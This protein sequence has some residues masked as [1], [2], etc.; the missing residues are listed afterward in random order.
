MSVRAVT[1]DIDTLCVNALRVLA[2][3]AVERAGSG[4]PGAPMGLAPVAYTLWG[5]ALRHDPTDPGWPDRDRFVLSAGHASALLYALL[6]LF[7]YELPLEELRRFRQWGSRTPG[8]PEHGLT[9]GVETTT[10]PLGQGLAN[11]VGM[12]IAERILAARF[13]R[14]GLEIV[15]HRVFAIC[16]DGDLMEGIAH[17]AASLAG[18]LG[19]GKLIVCYDD[20][21]ITIDGPTDLASSEDVAGRFRAYGWGV[22]RVE[23]GRDLRA[24]ARALDGAMAERDRPSL[25]LVRTTIAE[26]APT[27]AGTAE[28]HGAPL[29]SEEVAAWKGE[30]GWPDEPFHVPGAVRARFAEL[31][32]EGMRH[33]RAWVDRFARWRRAEPE[34]AS[35]WDRVM[36]RR[37]PA[38]WVE[39]LPELGERMAT[40]KAS[41]AV[42]AAL[43]PILPEL[44]GGSADLSGSNNTFLPGN[45]A[46]RRDRPGRYL[47]FGVREHAMGGVL[48]GIALHG[49]MRPYGGTFLVFSD[50]LR[51]AIR[52]SALMR[53]PVVY[54]FTHDSI[55]LG[56]DG[57]T[58]QPIEQLASLR[59]IPGLVV[60][61]PADGAE[62]VW[63]WRVALERIDGPTAIVLTRQDVPA[64]GP[65]RRTPASGL[66]R[67]AYVLAELA[68]EAA[69][70]P[71]APDPE[72]RPDA[73][74]IGTGSEV[75]LALEAARI[76]AAEGA[77]V[78]VVSMPSWELFERQPS[79]Y[80]DL[81][82]PPSVRARVAVEAGVTQGWERWVGDRGAVVGIDRFGASAPGP[83]LMERFGFTAERVASVVRGVLA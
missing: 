73:V 67:G 39:H 75:A 12:A 19:L 24:I 53:Q 62:T 42:L 17:E 9:P 52:L 35:E 61:R 32:R 54:V 80:R 71:G 56:E 11:A 44:V 29:G 79:G 69:E 6:H 45:A 50:Y 21:G 74:L 65:D 15:D 20:N 4:H 18:H 68:P 47:H 83:V 63:A 33:R 40:R 30:I 58:H 55:G 5:R 37:L 14:P 51:P 76:L 46:F 36:A 70:R 78:R 10:G 2:V 22:H 66:V 27:K 25:I 72:L 82:L 81:V 43:A 1:T 3:E 16:S 57:P 77:R 34:L 38:G 8:H 59:A 41:G 31:A 60:I 13:N 48:N 49:G 64:L 7:G 23:D 26:G 28:A